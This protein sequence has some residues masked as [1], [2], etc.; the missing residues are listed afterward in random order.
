MDDIEEEKGKVF[1]AS[2]MLIEMRGLETFIE[3]L[4]EMEENETVPGSTTLDK[5]TYVQVLRQAIS[6]YRN[7]MFK[8]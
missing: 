4:Q 8:K 2:L 3:Y 5:D 7:A 1:R 6:Q